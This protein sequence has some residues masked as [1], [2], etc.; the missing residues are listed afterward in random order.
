LIEPIR[1][2]AEEDLGIDIEFITED[3]KNAQQI[4]ALYP[5]SFD[6]YDQWFHN[7]DLIWPTRSVEPIQL[8]RIARWDEIN[9]LPKK[10]RLS[11]DAPLAPGGNPAQRL[12]VQDDSELGAKPTERISMLPTVHN[13]DSFACVPCG[14]HADGEPRVAS[15]ASLL[16]KKHHGRVAVQSDAAIGLMDVILAA[17][18][19]GWMT[20]EDPGNLSVEEIDELISRLTKLQRQGHFAAFWT[21]EAEAGALVS[22]E[23]VDV[24][25]MWWQGFV[26]LRRRGF[27]VTMAIPHEGYRG[28][29]GG[30]ALSRALNDKKRDAVY[31]YLN[32]WLDGYAGA[33]MMRNNAHIANPDAAKDYLS[34]SEWDYWY[35]GKP[36]LDDLQCPYGRTVVRRGERYPGGSYDQRMNRIVIW[37]SVMDEHN[38]L[39]R[40]WNEFLKNQA[41]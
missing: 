41:K 40:R 9:A 26:A 25:S 12:F 31:D 36:A 28:W 10:G 29:Y 21:T 24:S 3:G 27:A 17:M 5:Q 19:D 35:A 34:N 2:R 30:M 6:V 16:E 8:D 11:D 20:F 23:K 18:A 33:M 1:R 7:I 22:A 32:W 38:Y 14:D 37:N 13:A 4:A 39:V 15:W